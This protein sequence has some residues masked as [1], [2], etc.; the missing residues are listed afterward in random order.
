MFEF[1]AERPVLVVFLLVGIGS[2]LGRVRI[3]GVSLGA[4]AVLFTAMGL[5]AWAVTLDVTIELPALVGDLGLALFAFCV[6][7][8]AGPGFVNALKSAYPLLLVVAALTVAAAGVGYAL[9]AAMGLSPVTVAGTFAG[10]LT[11][12]PA[13]AATGGSP[14]ATVGYASAYVFGI[15]GAMVAIG[16]ALRHRAADTDAPQPL[17]ERAIRIEAA[18]HAD[19]DAL[20]RAHGGR[21]TISR[22]RHADGEMTTAGPESPLEPGAIVNVVGPKDAVD[23]VSADLGHTSAIDIV[24]DHTRLDFRR[25]ILSNPALA[26]RTI[27]SLR[28]REKY[29]ATIARVRRGDVDFV[30]TGGFVLQQGD[31]LRVVGPRTAMA[32]LTDLFGD[33]ERGIADINPIVL[34]L[35]IAAG[36]GLG[37]IR[38]PLP[39]VSGGVGGD[40]GGFALG[41]AAGALVIGLI[42]GRIGRI[43]P[44]V[45]TLPQTAAGVLSELGL[46]L[47]LAYAGT[48]AGTLIVSAIVS[49]EIVRL[50]LLGAAITT[51]LMAGTYLMA[52]HV[53][54]SGGTRLA[55]IVAGAQT[56]PALLAFANVRTGYD[57]RVALAYSLIYPF[58][59][60]VKILVAQV[61]VTL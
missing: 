57:V 45:T 56:N 31:R 33:S 43:G 9:G 15:V 27:A 42:F 21:V 4:I 59:M 30:G 32:E 14:E 40:G 18:S 54:R 46:L 20:I 48:K 22:I 24:H 19:V 17:V 34:G 28:L 6:G 23:A 55:G 49:G 16:L 37:A 44:V 58:A 61:L 26:G 12:T 52:R 8:I 3:A 13:L 38:V 36:L 50:L 47:F 7:L 53:F 39:G 1:L 51:I 60:V 25:V 10:A 2:A 29:G 41:A 11:N 5:T 35:G